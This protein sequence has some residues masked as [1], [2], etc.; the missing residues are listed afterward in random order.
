MAR[1]LIDGLGIR[2]TLFSIL[3]WM[4]RAQLAGAALV[5]RHRRRSRTREKVGSVSVRWEDS[6][7]LER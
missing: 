2:A 6:A 5:H 4:G 7:G 1:T 3:F